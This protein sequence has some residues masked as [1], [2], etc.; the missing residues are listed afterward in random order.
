VALRQIE[1]ISWRVTGAPHDV[2]VAYGEHGSWPLTWYMVDYPAAYFYGTSP[3]ADTLLDCP[4]VIAGSREWGVV[5]A[6]LQDEYIK[7][8]YVYLW[9]PVQDY[10]NLTPQRLWSAVSEPELRRALWDILWQRDYARYAALKSP[11]NPF[12]LK[13]W[14]YR[15]DFR[16]YVRR[17]LALETWP[18]VLGE[19][20][21]VSARPQPTEVPDPFEAGE[22]TLPVLNVSLLPGAVLRGLEVAP[23]GVLYVTDTAGHRVWRVDPNSQ[24]VTGWG[25]YGSEPGQFIEPWDVALDGDGNVYVTDTWNHRVQ[26]FD[27]QGRFLLAWGTFGQPAFVSDPA[28]QGVFY[29]PRGI[30]VSAS[31]EVYVTDTGNKR[32]QVF[33]SE[34]VFVREFGGSGTVPGLMNEPVGIALMDTGSVVVADAW[35]HRVQVFSSLG[36]PLQQWSIPGWTADNPEEKPMLAAAGDVIFVLDSVRQRVLA[37]DGAGHYLWAL[38][39]RAG[40]DLAFPGG[41][42]VADGVLYVADAHAGRILYLELPTSAE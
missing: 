10:F 40:A 13:T 7:F 33:T 11:D 26:K 23:D 16:L 4:V 6:I 39:G 25:T 41:V 5:E 31:N 17:D 1:E 30:A 18:E 3:N 34:G 36:M 20:Q 38:S 32:V 2:K 22:Q 35:N 29:G 14:P 19:A 9:W 15:E 37:F 8:D 24:T 21:G 12:T 42:A 28:G 27:G